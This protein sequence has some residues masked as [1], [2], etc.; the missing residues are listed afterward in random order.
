MDRTGLDFRLGGCSTL[1]LF[2]CLIDSR[3]RTLPSQDLERLKQRWG[4]LAPADGH[5]DR[6]KHLSRFKA[7]FLRD[8]T[9]G[10][11]QRV[12][13]E[14]RLRENFSSAGKNSER[15]GG[16]TLLRDQLGRVVG[17]ELIHKEE[18]GGSKN[19]AQK[20]DALTDQRSDGVHFSRDNRESGAA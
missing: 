1:Q 2:D 7:D 6:L 14:F 3:Q 9:E 10:L 11:I 17:R 13:A 18:V 12:V 4:V 16:V 15:H 20:F 8:R 19:V 5:S